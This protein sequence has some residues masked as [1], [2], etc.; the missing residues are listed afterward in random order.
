MNEVEIDQS[1]EEIS[2]FLGAKVQGLG[3][4]QD[5]LILELFQKVSGAKAQLVLRA[6]FPQNSLVLVDQSFG[7]IK[8]QTK[9]LYLFAKAHLIGATLVSA[10]REESVGRVVHLE[11]TGTDEKGKTQEIKLTQNLIPVAWNLTLSVG[12]K[13]VSL[14]KP[15]PIPPRPGLMGSGADI[16]MS[17]QLNK[18]KAQTVVLVQEALKGKGKTVGSIKVPP[19]E[20]EIAKKQKLLSKLSEDLQDKQ[21][22]KYDEFAQMVVVDKN[23]AAKDFPHF[24]D[25]SQ[26]PHVLQ[27]EAFEKHKKN[28]QKIERILERKEEIEKEVQELKSMSPQ[29]WAKAYTQKAQVRLG[30]GAKAKAQK[31]PAIEA[32]KFELSEDCVAYLGKSAQHN[33]SLLRQAKAWHFWLHIKDRPSAYVLVQCPKTKNSLSFSEV[34]RILRWWK[35]ASSS[36]GKSLLAG[37]KLSILVTQCRYVRP[38]KG[39]KLGRVHYSHEQVFTISL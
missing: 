5:T 26:N 20:K 35:E 39:D 13:A 14:N 31:T 8:S 36:L 7:K 30:S 17:S 34:D 21:A 33:L 38:I 9:P 12:N 22:L 29:E 18:V 24:F 37:E 6:K 4:I 19:I 3:F 23:L 15:K 10:E 28:L 32:R 11:F 27:K 25:A 2:E 1:L 16:K